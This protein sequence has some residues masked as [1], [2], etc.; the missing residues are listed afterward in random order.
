MPFHMPTQYLMMGLFLLVVSAFLG[1]CW[2]EAKTDLPGIQWWAGGLAVM[3]IAVA[4]VS[5]FAVFPVLLRATVTA[6]FGLGIALVRWGVL[7]LDGRDGARWPEGSLIVVLFVSVAS[8]APLGLRI[9]LNALAFVFLYTRVAAS[10]YSVGSLRAKSLSRY[11]ALFFGMAA[12]ATLVRV[13]FALMSEDA[14]LFESTLTASLALMGIAAAVGAAGVALVALVQKELLLRFEEA[15]A[16][17]TILSGLLPI[18]ASCKQIR[19]DEGAWSQVEEYVTARSE[20]EFT[21]SI[22]PTCMEELYPEM[23]ATG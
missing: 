17:V 12:A 22:C 21:H 3:G 19:D 6:S 1:W 18:C 7:Q 11:V 4:S 23:A 5:F 20:A 10:M 9:A 8:S 13:P 2:N 14:A 15:Q 16:R